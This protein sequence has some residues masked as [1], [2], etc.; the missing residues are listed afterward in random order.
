[1]RKTNNLLYIFLLLFPLT[2]MAAE[3]WTLIEK[4]N[5]F[6][7]SKDYDSALTRYYGAENI[8]SSE[9]IIPYNIACALYK[10]ELYDRSISKND[11][12]LTIAENNLELKYKA[13]TNKGNAAYQKKDFN[14]SI[15]AYKESLRLHPGDEKTKYNLALALHQLKKN[16]QQKQ[17][18]DKE[19]NK[20]SS[21]NKNEDKKNEDK[22]SKQN[23]D[24]NKNSEQKNSS[25]ENM[26]NDIKTQMLKM[27]DQQEKEVN[28][29]LMQG[30]KGGISG[31]EG[32][33]W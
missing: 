27:I 19:K 18:E 4:G 5:K 20:D 1:M 24:K 32:K 28:R 16:P 11:S 3:V 10:K 25:P 33:D 6:Y 22:N 29:R 12:A 17:N 7:F 31:S 21:D 8:D 2:L 15:D 9:S 30:D 14:A 26:N 23:Q 13:L